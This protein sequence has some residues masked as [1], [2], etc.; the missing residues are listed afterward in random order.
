MTE[1]PERRGGAQLPPNAVP[2]L[3]EGALRSRRSR[4]RSPPPQPPSR[5]AADSF[6]QQP[7][8]SLKPHRWSAEDRTAAAAGNPAVWSAA[9]FTVGRISS[10]SA[11]AVEWPNVSAAFIE[12][13]TLRDSVALPEGARLCELLILGVTYRFPE[14]RPLWPHPGNF[15]PRPGCRRGYHRTGVHSGEL[16]IDFTRVPC[17]K[18]VV[19]L[20]RR[21]APASP[22]CQSRVASMATLC[23]LP[24]N[25]GLYEHPAVPKPQ[26][27]RGELLLLLPKLQWRVSRQIDTL[28][29]E[30]LLLGGT[31]QRPQKRP[32]AH[33]FPPAGQINASNT[34]DD[35]FDDS[36]I[37][38]QME[39]QGVIPQHYQNGLFRTP[40]ESH[41]AAA[42]HE[43]Y[44]NYGDNGGV[45]A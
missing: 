13:S 33:G 39:A 19:F 12:A 11:A 31:T 26:P 18:A 4:S 32:A 34:A 1:L 44:L 41:Y 14:L 23:V 2:I 24:A 22:A 7:D 37:M 35:G 30:L 15:V 43:F 28:L 9:Q 8:F 29:Q 10:T 40:T 27:F 16:G 45:L 42:Q 6:P 38:A 20:T 21:G 17:L 25:A 5:A 3:R 36:D